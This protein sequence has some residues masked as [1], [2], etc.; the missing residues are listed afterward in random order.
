MANRLMKN[1][2]QYLPG[3]CNYKLHKTP[4]LACLTGCYQTAK[5]HVDKDM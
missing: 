3:K 5:F 2:A 1:G 4:L